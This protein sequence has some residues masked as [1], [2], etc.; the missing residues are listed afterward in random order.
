MMNEIPPNIINN[1]PDPIQIGSKK[2]THYL[3]TPIARY[4]TTPITAP[5]IHTYNSEWIDSRDNSPSK[6][7]NNIGMTGTQ[8][9]VTSDSTS[10]QKYDT[11]IKFKASIPSVNDSN[12][13][14]INQSINQP[15]N[16]TSVSSKNDEANHNVTAWEVLFSMINTVL[17]K[18]KFAKLGQYSLRLLIFHAKKTQKY[19]S[20]DNININVINK[21]YN[22]VDKKLN[23]F[24]NFLKHPQDFM[25]IILILLSSVILLRLAGMVQGLS[26]YRQFLRFGKSPFRL[27]NLIV[28]LKKEYDNRKTFNMSNVCNRALLGEIFGLYYSINDEASLLFKLKFFTNKD[29][30]K[31]VARHESLAW[32]YDSFLGLYNSLEKL[33][34]FKQQEMDLKI[35]VQV[36]NKAR[37]LSKQILGGTAYHTF[38]TNENDKEDLKLLKDIQFKKNNAYLDIYKWLSDII[39]NSYTVFDMALPFETLQIWMGISA[40][41]LSTVKIYRETKK[42]LIENPKKSN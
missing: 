24:L 18:D 11:P 20:D 8:V 13:S 23:L 27:R 22:R 9:F 10:R 19:L 6:V 1:H 12:T 35:Q 40:A 21:R 15:I 7:N 32:Y 34:D 4:Q 33:Q 39:F 37:H 5:L 29:I 26:T 36:K 16:M 3:D 42:R 14:S 2:T 25:K 28:K 31:F 30:R 38:D 17:G 41:A